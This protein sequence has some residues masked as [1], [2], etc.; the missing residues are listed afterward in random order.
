MEL[1]TA[2]VAGDGQR[3]VLLEAESLLHVL[4]PFCMSA[5]MALEELLGSGGEP[6]RLF[7][8]GIS[9]KGRV[10]SFHA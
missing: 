9:G 5:M 8:G 3:R 4:R 10:H 6:V 1:D 7:T 2:N